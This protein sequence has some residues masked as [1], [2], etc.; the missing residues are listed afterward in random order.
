MAIPAS[1]VQWI[2][3]SPQQ[4]TILRPRDYGSF[5]FWVGI[6]VALAVAFAL[7]ALFVKGGRGPLWIVPFIL[8]VGF[9]CAYLSFSDTATAVASKTQGTLQI[10]NNRGITD[11]YP[12]QSVQKL[13]VE[14]QDGNSRRMVFVLSTGV[15][16]PLGRWAT[17]EGLYQAA[18]AFNRF[19]SDSSNTSAQPVSS[20]P[21]LQKPDWAKS[22]QQKEEQQ[23]ADYERRKQQ[24][25]EPK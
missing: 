16:V 1:A 10:T 14:T 6:T 19:L 3:D 22:M 13:V 24:P 18:D 9:F 4:M 7:L 11:S 23:K 5:L 2:L 20:S 17:R 21:Q 15:D 8:L 12:L 25:S